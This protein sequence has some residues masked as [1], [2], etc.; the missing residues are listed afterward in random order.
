MQAHTIGGLPLGAGQAVNP[1]NLMSAVGGAAADSANR[2]AAASA[3]RGPAAGSANRRG[4]LWS[5]PGT[6][7]A[8]D[9]KQSLSSHQ[10]WHPHMQQQQQR[11]ITGDGG[12]NVR[13]A[14]AA[15]RRGDDGGGELAAAAR[16]VPP[17]EAPPVALYDGVA[18]DSANWP[19]IS[20]P[21]TSSF[22]VSMF[23]M[24]FMHLFMWAGQ[25][26]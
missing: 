26:F 1:R 6:A 3:N 4:G 15:G 14:E 13:G 8:A 11:C 24:H 19:M 20:I 7:E 2:G 17:H 5:D 25:W 18:A 9:S 16:G 22:Q 10:Q 12:G 23:F 21:S